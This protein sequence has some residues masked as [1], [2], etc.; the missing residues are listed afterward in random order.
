MTKKTTSLLLILL[1]VSNVIVA[2]ITK[3]SDFNKPVIHQDFNEED[4]FFSNY[5]ATN[6]KITIKNGDYVIDRTE[7]KEEYIMIIKKEIVI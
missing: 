3:T 5:T 1:F 2:Q 7:N 6:T 4:D